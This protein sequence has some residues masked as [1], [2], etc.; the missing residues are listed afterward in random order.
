MPN[1]KKK[2]DKVK[3]TIWRD[4]KDI[5]KLN[6]VREQLRSSS[7][8]DTFQNFNTDSEIY[9]KLPDLWL[10]AVKKNND[11]DLVIEELTA[12]L[13]KL[14]QLQDYICRIIEFCDIEKREE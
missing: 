8:I 12:K 14:Q 13:D 1:P 10:N 2:K 5:K 9:R 3:Y 4:Q 6:L 11:Q 7:D